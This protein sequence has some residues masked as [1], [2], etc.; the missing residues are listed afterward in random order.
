[1][2]AGRPRGKPPGDGQNRTHAGHAAMSVTDGCPTRNSRRV[3]SQL[4]DTSVPIGTRGLSGRSSDIGRVR[5]RPACDAW[6]DLTQIAVEDRWPSRPRPSTPTSPGSRLRCTPA[7]DATVL[8]R[9]LFEVKRVI[10]GQ[11]RMIERMFVGAAV[12]RPLPARGRARRG[13]DAR[14][15]DAGEGGRRHVRPH[16]VHPRPGARRHRRHPHLPAVQREVRRRARPGVRQL[17]ARRRDQPRAGQGAVGAAGGHGRAAGLDRRRDPPGARPVPGHGHAEP[18]RAGGRLP[19][20][21]GAARPVPD[22]D[23][24]RL[25]DRRRG[26]RD[27]LPDGRGAP[28]A[29]RRCSPRPTCSACRARPTRCSCTT[30]W[31]TTRC[32]WCWPPARRPSTA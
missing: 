32:G 19:A 18:D 26:A 16:P 13:Q 4:C 2:S 28:G 24:R 30:R 10:V 11:D 22:E 14:R 12:P 3:A 9:A 27:R 6:S 21:R 23:P 7:Q 31:S 25:P 29:E 17:P 20:A 8:E 15:G 5:L 1:M